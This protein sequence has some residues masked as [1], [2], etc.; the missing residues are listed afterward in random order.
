MIR[1]MIAD[2]HAIIRE[3]LKQ[4]FALVDDIAVVAEATNGAQALDRLRQ[5]GIDLL[6][7]DMTMPGVCGEDLVARVRAH[8]ET[9]PILILS[10][11]R[12]PQIAQRALK[13]GASGYL[14]KDR[15]PE[16]LL[17]AIR[18]TAAGGRF[19][20]PQL[21]EEMAFDASG[22]GNQPLHGCLTDRE[23]QIMRMLAR[24]TGIN[25][26]ADQLSISNKTVSTHKARL[27]EKMA[28]AS[29]ADIVRYAIA[30]HLTD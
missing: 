2:D 25:D 14:T 27:M 1:L 7:L 19:L 24:G 11:H 30:H 28:F 6:L 12:E 5:G 4:L 13:A 17:A 10:M 29:N 26:I 21:A 16:T 23:F 20:D 18:R 9:L 8:H 15:D 3:G 22:L